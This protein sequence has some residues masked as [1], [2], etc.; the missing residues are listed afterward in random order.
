MATYGTPGHLFAIAFAKAPTERVVPLTAPRADDRYGTVLTG[1]VIWSGGNADVW[2]DQLAGPVPPAR[3]EGFL[4]SY[5]PTTHGG[6]IVTRSGFPAAL[7]SVP[8]FTPSG[9]CPGNIAVLAVL[10]GT[11]VYEV[12]TG[13]DASTDQAVISSFRVVGR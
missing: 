7:E 8:C 13:L 12:H 11:T 5:L 6:R 1:R 4:R 3:V 10:A 2:V 9:S